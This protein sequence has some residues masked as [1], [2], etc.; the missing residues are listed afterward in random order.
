MSESLAAGPMTGHKMK[1]LYSS[2]FASG[3]TFTEIAAVGDVAL[4][5]FEREMVEFVSRGSTYKKKI[6]GPMEAPVITAKLI[7]NL[8]PTLEAALQA[9]LV[10]ATPLNLKILNGPASTSGVTGLQ[11]PVLVSKMPWN[12]SLSE[13]SSRDIQFELTYAV[14]SSTVQEPTIVTVA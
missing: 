7:H 3:A 13:V 1:L 10:N 12:Q 8:D 2:S 4:E 14:D 6:A 9:A 11:L 5:T